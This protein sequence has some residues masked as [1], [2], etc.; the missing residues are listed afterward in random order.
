MTREQIEALARL[1]DRLEKAFPT[2]P[3]CRTMMVCTALDGRL[4]WCS[5]H[6]DQELR[7]ESS[8]EVSR[9]ECR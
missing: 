3:E 7:G 4:V 9:Y 1:N 6:C 2:M 5:E 8:F